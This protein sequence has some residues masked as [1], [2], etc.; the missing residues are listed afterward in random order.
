MTPVLCIAYSGFF[1]D[2]YISMFMISTSCKYPI[3]S[4]FTMKALLTS[5]ISCPL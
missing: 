5:I 2:V 4:I 3:T 1:I